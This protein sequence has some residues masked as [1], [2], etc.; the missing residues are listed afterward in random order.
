MAGG[1][2]KNYPFEL[3]IKC[4]IFSTIIII[5]FFF[6]PPEM[7][8]IWKSF[9]AFIL[10][11]VAYVAMAWYDYKFEC[12]KLALKR[13]SKGGITTLFKPEPHTKSQTD[14]SKETKDEKQLT[15][16]LINIYHLFIITPLVIY[17]GTYGDKSNI[18]AIVVLIANLAFA[19]LYHIV[20]VL[21]RFN[22]ISASHVLGGIIG[23]VYLLFPKRPNAFYYALI[24]IGIYAGLKHGYWLM[25]S[26]HALHTD[27]EINLNNSKN[28]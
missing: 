18:N 4:V 11:V 9:I 1:L 28:K 15:M 23:I 22:G 16:S 3:N 7:N 8:I 10:F 25:K 17:I 26:S 5:L 13:G 6:H 27:V 21:R 24:F 19:I 14:S 12:T 2:F 20:R